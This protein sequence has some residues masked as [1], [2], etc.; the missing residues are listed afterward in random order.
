M[1]HNRTYRIARIQVTT[2]VSEQ[3]IYLSQ[4]LEQLDLLIVK[5][6]TRYHSAREVSEKYHD[7]D[8]AKREP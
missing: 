6:E 2:G 7:A 3:I 4:A 8:F 1:T 5:W